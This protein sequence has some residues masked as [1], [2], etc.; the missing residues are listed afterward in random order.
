VCQ[1]HNEEALAHVQGERPRLL[2][3]THLLAASALPH[4]GH[5]VAIAY[6]HNVAIAYDTAN[7]VL[8]KWK[9]GANS[10]NAVAA[11]VQAKQAN[12]TARYKHR[13]ALCKALT[14][15]TH[16]EGKSIMACLLGTVAYFPYD[17]MQ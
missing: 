11:Q 13:Q 2:H 15:T 6:D 1:L 10:S 5:N 12:L 9:D 8:P 14:H 3:S 16:T 7:Q 17:G 4:L